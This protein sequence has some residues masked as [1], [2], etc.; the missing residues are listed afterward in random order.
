MFLLL[1]RELERKEKVTSS[2]QERK[3]FLYRHSK[4][5]VKK[6]Q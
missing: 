6:K 4:K 1:F 5:Q 3:P 2:L